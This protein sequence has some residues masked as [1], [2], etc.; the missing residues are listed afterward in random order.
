M[1]MED[2]C[3]LAATCT[4]LLNK[5]LAPSQPTTHLGTSAHHTFTT[6]FGTLSTALSRNEELLLILQALHAMGPSKSENKSQSQSS[7][8]GPELEQQPTEGS[9]SRLVSHTGHLFA[10]PIPQ[11]A[12]K[13]YMWLV[14]VPHTHNQGE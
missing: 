12:T 8:P 9:C 10:K 5:Y 1:M 6:S 3:P 2:G 7:E 11:S 4:E 13:A 14:Y